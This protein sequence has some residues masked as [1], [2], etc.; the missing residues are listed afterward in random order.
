[1]ASPI[2]PMEALAIVKK[3]VEIYQ[4]IREAPDQ[5]KKVGRRMERLE[6]YL[7]ALK[8]LLNQ[9]RRHAL[10]SL[11][12]AQTRELKVIL[13]DIEDDADKVYKILEKWDKNIGPF[14]LQFRFKSVAE[15]LFALGSNLKN[16]EELT[17]EI[18]LHKNDVSVLS[19]KY[20]NP[21]E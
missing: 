11:R 8:E 14:G 10:A 12:P 20:R 4:K 16:L 2:S 19:C 6:S 18:E 1:M 9:K 13:K 7:E 17:E 5:M 21:I 3:A 15:A